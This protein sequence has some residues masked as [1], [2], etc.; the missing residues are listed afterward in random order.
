MCG[1]VGYVGPRQA[2]SVIMQGLKRLEYRGYDSAGIAVLVENGAIAIRRRRQAQEPEVMLADSPLREIGI[3]TRAGRRTARPQRN[4]HPHVAMNERVVVVHNGIVENYQ[5]LRRA[6][7]DRL[8]RIRTPEVIV[9][10]LERYVESGMTLR[11][12]RRTCPTSLKA[13]RRGAMS[14]V[15]PDRLVTTRLGNAAITLGLG[16]GEM[17][18][19]S[20][21]RRS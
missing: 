7:R 9:Q 18:I 6:G 12:P 14:V 10:L 21:F 2:P 11:R 1:I 17:F 5:R 13:Q 3:G 16:E 8:A 19:A 15:E 4:A 20:I